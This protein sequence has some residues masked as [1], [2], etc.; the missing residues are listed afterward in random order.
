VVPCILMYHA[1]R[2]S[3]AHLKK[4]K[5]YTSMYKCKKTAV[6]TNVDSDIVSYAS[7][8]AKSKR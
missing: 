6:Y 5:A 1:S 4:E 7:K 8:T 3:V 2:S